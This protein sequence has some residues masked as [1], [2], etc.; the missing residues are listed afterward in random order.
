VTVTLI[1]PQDPSE[2][3]WEEMVRSIGRRDNVNA[4]MV[5][6][7]NYVQNALSIRKDLEQV[8]ATKGVTD[9][10]DLPD[11]VLKAV[12]NRAADD[13][14]LK[15]RCAGTMS[16]IWSLVSAS[17]RLWPLIKRVLTGD[18]NVPDDVKINPPT[19][20]YPFTRIGGMPEEVLIDFFTDI[21]DG[22]TAV[23]SLL[24]LCQRHKFIDRVSSEVCDMI[25]LLSPDDNEVAQMIRDQ[26][27]A[28]EPVDMTRVKEM[29]P[30][31]TR[32]SDINR[33]A[34]QVGSSSIRLKDPIPGFATWA[35]AAIVHDL[36]VIKAKGKM[37]VV[38]MVSLSL[39]LMTIVCNF[40]FFCKFSININDN[41][42]CTKKKPKTTSGSRST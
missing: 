31:A 12:R 35:H 40:I 32:P 28:Q 27:N 33:M 23:T 13:Y 29:F 42:S 9:V 11:D 41:C 15:G 4:T 26:R 16:Q 30:S 25:A 24:N 1:G 2:Q 34:D 3:G 8:M 19:S 22:R 38:S 39:I 6:T 14:D 10:R 18:F 5:K 37:E 20:M 21:V 17:N 36:R 7:D